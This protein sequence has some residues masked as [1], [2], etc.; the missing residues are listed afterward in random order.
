[1]WYNTI[2]PLFCLDFKV[3]S[4]ILKIIFQGSRELGA[5]KLNAADYAEKPHIHYAFSVLL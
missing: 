5:D 4:G 1:M 2:I 3:L